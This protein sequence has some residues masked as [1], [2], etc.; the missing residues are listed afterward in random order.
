VLCTAPTLIS[1]TTTPTGNDQQTDAPKDIEPTNAP[2]KFAAQYFQ[3]PLLLVDGNEDD[4]GEDK[5]VVD[6]SMSITDLRCVG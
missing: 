2:R 3:A 1:A 6:T 5:V 4:S